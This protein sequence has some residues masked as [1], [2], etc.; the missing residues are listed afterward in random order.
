MKFYQI[1]LFIFAFNASISVLNSMNLF[2]IYIMHDT[3]WMEG[4]NQS[5]GFSGNYT[6]SSTAVFGDFVKG[7]Q[8]ITSALGDATILLPFFLSKLGVPGEMNAIITSGTW[9]VYGIAIAQ[10]L[11]GRKL[12]E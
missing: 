12:E 4:L 8:I 9:L 1:A 6:V 10:F 2:G 5:S 11:S 3:A 7:L